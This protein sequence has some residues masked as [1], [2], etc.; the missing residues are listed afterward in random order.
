MM[1]PDISVINNTEPSAFTIF[2]ANGDSEVLLLC[3]HASNY[4]P[5][6]YQRLGLT[7]QLLEEHISWDPGAAELARALALKLNAPLILGNYSRLLI[8]LNR[9]LQAE[10]C[11]PLRSEHHDIPGNQTLTATEREWRTE[12]YYLPFHLQVSRLLDARLQAGKATR[13]VGVHS[14]TPVYHGQ[15]RP[16]EIGILY[17]EASDYAHLLIEGLSSHPLTVGDNQPYN[18]HP[19]EDMTVP[20]H[21][22]ARGLPAVLLEI[23]NDLLRNE[24]QIAQWATRLAPLLSI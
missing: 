23:R 6:R 17:G 5:A 13:V 19:N 3:E 8:D 10:D 9:P 7:P 4:I 14:F 20:V 1:N 22:D 24:Q 21:G 18:I 16:W 15:S 12:Q 2:N 11:I